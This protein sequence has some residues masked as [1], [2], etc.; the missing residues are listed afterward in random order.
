MQV[1]DLGRRNFKEVWD[2][3]HEIHKMR[4]AGE[5]ED[6]L[7]L[8]EHDPV[9]TI[10]KNGNIRN[11]LIAPEV[12]RERGIDFFRIERGGDVTFHGPGQLV[13]YPIFEIKSGFAGIRP[14][15][16]AIEDVIIRVLDRLEISANRGSHPGLWV[17]D[18]KILSIGIA[19]RRWISFH[20]FALNVNNDPSDFSVINPCGHAGM[21]MTSIKETLKRPVDLDLIKGI[22]IKGFENVYAQA[23]LAQ[24]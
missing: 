16:K 24:D 21:L 13:G 19:V 23:P 9:V 18:K 17:D 11:L 14:F 5:I 20:G 12:L 4:V 8:V 3:Q 2:L 22:I 6:T 7:I 10:G 1:L 15:I